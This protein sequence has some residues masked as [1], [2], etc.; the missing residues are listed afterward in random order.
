VAGVFKSAVYGLLIALAEADT[1][2]TAHLAAHWLL[3]EGRR[4]SA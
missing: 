4:R 2:G 3:R 1:A